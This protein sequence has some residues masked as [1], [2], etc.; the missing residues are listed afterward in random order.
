MGLLTI[1]M[2]VY[3]EERTVEQAVER[4]ALQALPAG[5]TREIILVNDGSTDRS[6]EILQRLPS[7]FPA[8]AFKQVDKPKN[9]GKGAALRA[10]WPL[11]AGD[12]LLIQDADLEYDPADYPKLL[13]PILEGRADAVFGSRFIGEPHRALFFW[14]QKGNNLLTGFSNLLSDLNLTD[15]EAGYKVFTRAVYANLSIRSNGFGV[16]PELTMKTAR[17]RLQGRRVRIFETGVSY[18]GRTYEEGKKIS[19]R[20]A[21]LA[22][23][24][25]PFFR[26]FD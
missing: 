25:I 1:L 10:G 23:A 21:L 16:E 8:V 11:A 3:N 19:W 24:Q 20:D 7:R 14:H 5:W 13:R 17:L 9:E 6:G 12:I 22:L 18:A 15:M 2:P 26:F 4:A